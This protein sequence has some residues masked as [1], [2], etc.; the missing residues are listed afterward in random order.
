[1]WS[2]PH[3]IHRR[4]HNSYKLESHEGNIIK[5]T[6]S[7]RWLRAFIPRK[8]TQLATEQKEFKERLKAEGPSSEGEEEETEEESENE[9]E[10]AREDS[11][12]LD[13]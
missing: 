5:G 3:C 12:L 6:F 11:E 9:E 10:G 8:G 4:L 7:S 2:L 13:E 1:M